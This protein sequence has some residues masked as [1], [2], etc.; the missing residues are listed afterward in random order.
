[1]QKL[2]WATFGVIAVSVRQNVFIANSFWGHRILLGLHSSSLASQNVQIDVTV[3][4]KCSVPCHCSLLSF[5]QFR[6]RPYWPAESPSVELGFWLYYTDKRLELCVRRSHLLAD[7]LGELSDNCCTS[8]HK[9]F[10]I[11]NNDPQPLFLN[12]NSWSCRSIA[13]FFDLIGP[14]IVSKPIPNIW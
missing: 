8:E 7:S 4:I 14:S 9:Q 1:M 12:Q 13:S 2:K 10:T 11:S 3:Y 5:A 6:V